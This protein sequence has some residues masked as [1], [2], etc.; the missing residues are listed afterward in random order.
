MFW[1]NPNSLKPLLKISSSYFGLEK[2][3]TDGT[4]PHAVERLF[5]TISKSNGYINKKCEDF[6]NF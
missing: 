6:N 4:T 1:L 3:L 2:G 5:I